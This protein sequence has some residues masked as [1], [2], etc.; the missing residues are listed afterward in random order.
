MQKDIFTPPELD[1]AAFVLD[2]KFGKNSVS[3]CRAF[4]T[5]DLVRYNS[6][7]NLEFV[8]RKDSR[9]VS[10]EGTSR[11]DNVKE[12]IMS[13]SQGIVTDCVV[14]DV[15][16]NCQS[17]LAAFIVLKLNEQNDTA[18]DGTVVLEM[19]PK[20]HYQLKRLAEYLSNT[21][22]SSAVPTVYIPLKFLP[23]ISDRQLLVQSAPPEMPKAWAGE[24]SDRKVMPTTEHEGQLQQLWATVFE[25]SKDEIGIDDNFFHLGGDSLG[26]GH[27][28]MKRLSSLTT[29][30][31]TQCR[32]R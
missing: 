11:T 7:A 19:T 21:L 12:V 24:K 1:D 23:N 20:M 6:K 18:E 28:Y 31:Q 2:T 29:P 14:E 32:S 25:K 27:T 15:I 17:S 10:S 5:G 13:W 4:K 22:P 16:H 8:R 3:P 30:L 26:K 9:H